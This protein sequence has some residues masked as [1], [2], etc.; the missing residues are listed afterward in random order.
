MQKIV[1][2]VKEDLYASLERDFKTFVRLS[3]KFDSQFTTPSFENF[4]LAKM[5]DNAMPLTEQAVQH[6]M[7]S[8]QYAWAKRAL[9]KD[10]PEVVSILITQAAEHGFNVATRQD[11]TTEDLAT[12][13]KAWATAIV[14]ESK[15]DEMQI[16]ILAAQIKSSAVSILE[17]EAK[18]KTPSWRL[19]QVLAQK[20][21]DVIIAVEHATGTTAREKFGELRCLLKL[22]IIN[23]TVSKKT[24]EEILDGLRDRKPFLFEEEPHS[25]F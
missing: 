15:G 13:A 8:G 14:R 25:G 4:L 19:S 20:L 11:W 1:L 6:V 23:G 24:E 9:D 2:N 18:L 7:L 17:V 5:A 16:D 3:T 10:F 21:H 12:A 22:S